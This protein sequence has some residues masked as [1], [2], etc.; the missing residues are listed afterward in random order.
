MT[1]SLRV[2]SLRRRRKTVAATAAAGSTLLGLLFSSEPGSPEFYALTLGVASVWTIGGATS[3]SLP[4][5]SRVEAKSRYRQLAEPVLIGAS[6][7]AAFY[8]A[9]LVARRVPVLNEAVTSVL[10]YAHLGS[11]R[12]VMLTS[13][14]NGAAE[15]VFFRGALY[16]AA[17]AEH[18]V[19]V[20][21]AGYVLATVSTRNPALVLASAV[22]GALFA[23]QRRASGGIQAPIISHLTWTALMLRFLPP[24]FGRASAMPSDSAS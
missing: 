17:G 2:D 19:A 4:L 9:A 18:P 21:T 23:R 24:L 8:G 6:A 3:G 16:A 11:D 10:D 20:S 12:L 5:R 7:F 14:A 15:E 1:D 13:L 22:M